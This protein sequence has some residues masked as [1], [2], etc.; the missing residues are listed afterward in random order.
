MR[1]TYLLLLALF[2]AANLAAQ[3]RPAGLD[4]VLPPVVIGRQAVIHSKR[5]GEDRPVLVHL[6]RSYNAQPTMR[7]PVLYLLDGD[8]HFPSVSAMVD[9]LAS[10]SRAPE[11]IVV[12]VPN[13]RDRTHDLTPAATQR[14]V[15]FP[16]WPGST[17]S[18]TQSFPTAGGAPKMRAFL[19]EELV[20]WVETGFRTAPYRIL[21]GHSFGG[22]FALDALA[23][24]PRSFNAYVAISPS[25]WW[26]QGLYEK[27]IET[28]LAHAALD[29]RALYMTTGSREPSEMI[30]PARALAAALDS[31]HVAGFR[32]W[33]Q[34]MPSETHN[35]NP[36]RTTYDALEHIFAGWEPPDS[37]I[38]GALRGDIAAMEEHY[39]ELTQRFGFPVTLMPDQINV[40]A[41][42]NLQ[43]KKVD[44]AVSLFRRNVTDA[45]QYANG[46]DSLADGL[47]AQGKLAEALAAAEKAVSLGT[48]QKDPQINAYQAHLDRLR[49][50]APRR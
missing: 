13:T 1:R 27:R 14:S 46:W 42:L 22:L 34:V 50:L 28:A 7:Y 29:G 38:A 43:A 4:S 45:P 17:D 40:V 44:Y 23:E 8:A 18:A 6:P 26:D 47:E 2:P 15:R 16:V 41:Y 10:N 37:A 24:S 33:Y 19:T 48:A 39:A 36:L 25:L 35:S 49:K 31:A 3:R 5:L 11:M 12:G 32:S 9:F 30:D 20:P 21:V